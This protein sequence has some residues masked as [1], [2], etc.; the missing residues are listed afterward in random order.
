MFYTHTISA[1]VAIDQLSTLQLL[2]SSLATFTRDGRKCVSLRIRLFIGDQI[3]WA[4]NQIVAQNVE[5][6]SNTVLSNKNVNKVCKRMKK[7]K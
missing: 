2:D 5:R 3:L 4:T 6:N 1:G 7:R